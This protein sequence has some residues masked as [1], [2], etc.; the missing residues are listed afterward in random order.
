[1]V[2]FTA[3]L[4]GTWALSA[5]LDSE[6]RE[7]RILFWIWDV[8]GRFVV[9]GGAVSWVCFSSVGGFG[10]RRRMEVATY[11]DCVVPL[12]GLGVVVAFGLV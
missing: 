8:R 9:L 7:E 2:L 5:G 4:K 6:I 1:M 3:N 12:F 11:D 10:F